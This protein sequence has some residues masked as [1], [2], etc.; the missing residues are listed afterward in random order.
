MKVSKEVLT[1]LQQ[2]EDGGAG[3]EVRRYS[4]KTNMTDISDR[5]LREYARSKMEG[6]TGPIG[7]DLY[8]VKV[9]RNQRQFGLS[10]DEAIR[11]AV[12]GLPS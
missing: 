12:K 1:L 7:F 9:G 5:R 4:A 2:L 8:A 3:Y 11:A 10:L 6:R